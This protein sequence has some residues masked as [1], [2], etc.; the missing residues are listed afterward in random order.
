[1]A[2]N[3][4]D[5]SWDLEKFNIQ[6]QAVLKN[7]A[8]VYNMGKQISETAIKPGSMGGFT[9]LKAQSDQF[10]KLAEAQNNYVQS[11]QRVVAITTQQNLSIQQ[12]I[13]KLN[14]YK[15]ALAENSAALKELQKQGEKSGLSADEYRFKI[16]RL[17]ED[18]FKYKQSISD[19]T[20]EIK[21]QQ[22]LNASPQNTVLRAQSENKVLVAQRNLTDVNDVQRIKEL[23]DQIDR[24]N[25]LIDKN[26]DLLG[27]QKINIGNYPNT[28]GTAFKTLN[29]ELDQVKNKLSSG[30][31]GGESIDKLTTKL[32]VLQNAASLTGKEFKTVAQQQKAYQEA[33][34][35]IGQVYGKNSSVFKNFAS[36]VKE[37]V[38]Q[39]A[40][41][42]KSVSKV[43]AAGN[44]VSKTLTG[45]YNGLRKI[46]YAI[47]GIGIGGL[48][49]LLLGP[50][51]ALGAMLFK[52][53]EGATGLGKSFEDLQKRTKDIE[54]DIHETSKQFEDAVKN[55]NELKINIDLAKQGFLDKDKV[56]KEYNDTIGKTTGF[57][58][59]LDEAEKELVKNGDAYIQM[60]LLKAAADVALQSAAKSTFEAEE[61]RRKALQ[62]FAAPAQDAVGFNLF[63][64][65]S[66]KELEE[67]G[68]KEQAAAKKRKADAVKAAVDAQ[69][70]QLDIAKKF[71]EEAAEIA[72]KFKFNFFGGQ[73]GGKGG[74]SQETSL[75]DEF[76]KKDLDALSKYSS[77]SLKILQDLYKEQ[78]NDQV[79][80]LNDRLNAAQKY[81]DVSNQLLTNQK[82][83]EEDALNLEINTA[84]KKAGKIKD[85][86]LRSETEIAIDKYRTD[87]LKEI[88]QTFQ[89]GSLKNDQSFYSDK[90]RISNDAFE[91]IRKQAEEA[92]KFIQEQQKIAYQ[93]Q[94]DQI[95][96]N[97][98]NQLLDLQKS[99]KGKSL[100]D[101]DEFNAKKKAIEDAA[102]IEQKQ[103]EL[104]RLQDAE[105]VTEAL[106][107]VQ[108]LDFIKKAKDL[109]VSITEA[110][111]KKILESQ[112]ALLD[113]KKELQQQ[114]YDLLNKGLETTQAFVD[115]GYDK[116]KEQYA[117]QEQLLDDN[118]KKE[119]D[120]INQSTISQQ[121]KAAMEKMINASA[122]AEKK[123][124]ED[125]QK[126]EEVK[127]AQFDKAISVIQIGITTA[128]A[129]A[130]I[131]AAAAVARA[132]YAAIPGVGLVAGSAVAT[133]LLAQIPFIV[134]TGALEAAAVLAKP[135]P[136]YATGTDNHPG[137]P[138][139]VGE[140]K[141]KELVTDPSGKSFIAEKPTFIPDLLR[142]SK[143]TPLTKEMIM[144]G[145]TQSANLS[146]AERIVLSNSIQTE[147]NRVELAAIKEAVYETGR[148]TAQAL[149]K[150]KGANVVVN[151]DSKFYAHI[152]KVVK[153]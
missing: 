115:A 83:A 35:Q 94:K 126:E 101:L 16:N 9:E 34:I 53:S 146:M 88:D 77:D 97:K 141:H 148:M 78:M 23:N 92:A 114:E 44:V 51:Q 55:V 150:Q 68:K 74:A 95:D 85:P 3:I 96:I 59:S 43:A 111:N 76:R 125:K 119:I 36:Q 117:K 143:V 79:A 120:A 81:Y 133:T 4:I 24:N 100:K 39:N 42:A 139:I 130:K 7:M 2:Q 49:L 123:Q 13:K 127:K 18:Q 11:T 15:I 19:I 86:K 10:T 109:E 82:Q 47:P 124:L 71:Q 69:N 128:E 110:G 21:A 40:G 70:E 152:M 41:F 52:A 107:G 38:V 122:A 91:K 66:Q 31:L 104:K 129:V 131:T 28:F 144:E 137:G 99:Y 93:N 90:V 135:I 84:N 108:N 87:K 98:D 54:A 145:M 147:G 103:L 60:M 56:V 33:A 26:N 48:V 136:A 112:K 72:K 102:D 113:A 138:A 89:S 62:D 17:T 12:N 25:D 134:A 106:Y 27:R 61:N 14:D 63:G 22:S 149:K 116:K 65:P 142:G 46:A 45:A 32:N 132:T 6:T 118:T 105:K 29:T 20:K 64:T 67:Q 121:E 151:V 50:L 75:L 1:M 8:D 153:E 30:N 80:S 57:V 58:K 73:G 140:G 5:V 37:G